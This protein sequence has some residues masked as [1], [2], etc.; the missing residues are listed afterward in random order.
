MRRVAA[1]TPSYMII[2]DLIVVKG[3]DC[4]NLYFFFLLFFLFRRRKRWHEARVCR[5]GNFNRWRQS[6]EFWPWR[7]YYANRLLWLWKR[8]QHSA[9]RAKGT[10]F[11]KIPF[12]PA[13]CVLRTLNGHLYPKMRLEIMGSVFWSVWHVITT[14]NMLIRQVS[15]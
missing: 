6:F 3:I 9:N 12:F 13:L 10:R 14:K 4:S 15:E 8:R 11:H 2:F 1:W 7:Q 5:Q